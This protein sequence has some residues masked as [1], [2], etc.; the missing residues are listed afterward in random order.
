MKIDENHVKNAILE[1]LYY[2]KIFCW[3]QNSMGVYDKDKGIYRKARGKFAING[4][5]DIIGVLPDGKFLGVEVKKP[6]GKVSANQR[7]FKANVDKNKGV[8]IIAYSLEHFV[9]YLREAG[10]SL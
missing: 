1:W 3:R 8:S 10:Y 2:K 6:T 7:V 4:V 9:F 5:P